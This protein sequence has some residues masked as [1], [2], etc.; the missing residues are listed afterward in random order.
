[1][2]EE[3]NIAP[4][5]QKVINKKVNTFLTI[6]FI[7]EAYYFDWL[8]NIVMIKKANEKWKIYIHYIDLNKACMKDSFLLSKINQ[9]INATSG[10]KL[11]SFM[12]VFLGYNQI[13][14]APKNEKNI[15]F[16]TKKGICYYKV[17][18][19]FKIQVPP[20]NN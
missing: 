17:M 7:Y 14:M 19:W 6:E 16:V 20:T 8:A 12:N 5:R 2:A 13:R 4:K 10:H 11:L 9:L 3:K 1:M 15:T 18:S